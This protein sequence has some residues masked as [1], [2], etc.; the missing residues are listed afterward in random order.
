LLEWQGIAVRYVQNVT[1]IDDD[2]LRKARETGEDWFSL[3]NRWVRRFVDDMEALNVRP[4]EVFPR[5]SETIPA[6]IEVIHALLAQGAAYER[7]GSIYYRASLTPFGCLSRL[8]PEDWLRV[9]AERGNVA[10][11]PNKENPM[12]FPLW[13]M[14]RP[15]EPAWP[16]PWGPGGGR[17]AHHRRMGGAQGTLSHERDACGLSVW[18]WAVALVA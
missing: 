3:G 6:M 2:I 16:S 9:A 4:P 15:G 13:Q 12:D 10:E 18:R 14:Q 8:A 1:D 17:A 11:D 5:A 7:G